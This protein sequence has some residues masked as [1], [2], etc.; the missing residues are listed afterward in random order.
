MSRERSVPVRHQLERLVPLLNAAVAGLKVL[1][2]VGDQLAGNVFSLGLGEELSEGRIALD[3]NAVRH[4]A[5]GADPRQH[6]FGLAE[7]AD[8]LCDPQVG[9]KRALFDTLAP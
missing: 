3:R 5:K 4:P 1:D 9:G 2:N 7:S 8:A 6:L